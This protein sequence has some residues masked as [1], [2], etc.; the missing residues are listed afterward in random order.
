MADLSNTELG[1][2]AV[3][4]L[5]LAKEFLVP[6]VKGSLAR[7]LQAKD[8]QDKAVNQKLDG[9]ERQL[10]ELKM[11][12]AQVNVLSGRLEALDTRIEKQGMS[13]EKK[14]KDAVAEATTE[15]N[16]KLASTLNVELERTVREVL[17]EELKRREP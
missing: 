14:L 1:L 17:R 7:N 15:F 16:R 12:Q 3:G 5:Y 6:L 11:A 13:H 4:A 2:Y 8:D 10:S 9:H